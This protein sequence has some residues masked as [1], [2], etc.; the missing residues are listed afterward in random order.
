MTSNDKVYVVLVE[1]PSGILEIFG[2]YQTDDAAYE[3]LCNNFILEHEI[4]EDMVTGDD[5]YSQELSRNLDKAIRQRD[6]IG[7][8]DIF[9][10][11]CRDI[12]K[13]DVYM[14]VFEEVVQW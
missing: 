5:E 4:A 7:A 8:I 12:A 6:W 1:N 13:R 14:M 10:G 3:E 2:V 9:Q 11:Y